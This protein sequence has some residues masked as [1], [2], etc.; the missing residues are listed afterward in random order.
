M[1][2]GISMLRIYPSNTF[3]NR[4]CIYWVARSAKYVRVLRW[5]Q[6]W[7]LSNLILL[8]T[9][10]IRAAAQRIKTA[11]E[12]SGFKQKQVCSCKLVAQKWTRMFIFGRACGTF[13]LYS[14][15]LHRLFQK[16]YGTY[17]LRYAVAAKKLILNV[18]K[19]PRRAV[20]LYRSE[21]CVM[22]KSR[23]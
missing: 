6:V 1:R 18:S 17:V 21:I 13:L 7:P 14:L 5:T 10:G 19:L 2:C 12:G 11:K 16:A 20:G 4:R 3:W 9:S 8:N 15:Y 23:R 22:H